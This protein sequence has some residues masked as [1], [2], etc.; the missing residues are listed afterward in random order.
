MAML[1]LELRDNVLVATMN[2]NV[3]NTID[4]A[5]ADEL[6]NALEQAEKQQVPLLHLRTATAHFCGG[7]DPTRVAHWLTEAGAEGLRRDGDR[8]DGLFRRIEASAVTVFAEMKGNALGAGLGLALACD[9]RI[10]SATS[11]IG[12][13]EVRV[14]LLPAGRTVERLVALAGTAAAQRLLLGGD[15]IDGVEAHRLN[16]AHWLA[17]V[18][19]LEARAQSLVE[20]IARQSPLAMREA[21]RLL[22]ATRRAGPAGAAEVEIHAFER[23]IHS[24][25][26]RARI[27]AL[28]G[29]LARS[30]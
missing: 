15:I 26:P 7:A 22:T 8:W 16:L 20:R 5:L 13:P 21:K 17:P 9:L 10:M 25:D 14:G 19:E 11:R 3:Q 29:R 30:G 12:V 28:L 1:T 18:E 23:L 27:Q 6:E 2:R 4:G 24:D